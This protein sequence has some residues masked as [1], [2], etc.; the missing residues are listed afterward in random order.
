[1]PYAQKMDPKLLNLIPKETLEKFKIEYESDHIHIKTW[2]EIDNS[3]SNSSN[4][5][6]NSGDDSQVS[7]DGTSND[8]NIS[9]NSQAIGDSSD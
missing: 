2:L 3:G 4:S 5:D 8:Q 1:M 9:S 7:Q 6:G